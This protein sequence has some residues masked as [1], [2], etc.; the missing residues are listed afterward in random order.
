MK[1]S[2]NFFV[3]KKAVNLLIHKYN[4]TRRKDEKKKMFIYINILFSFIKI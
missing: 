4:V 2:P 1:L 3:N